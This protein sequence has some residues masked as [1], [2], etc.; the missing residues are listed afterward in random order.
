[1]S[2][3]Q[4]LTGLPSAAPGGFNPLLNPY[5][6]MQQGAGSPLAN[7]P[8]A[9]LA[10]LMSQFQAGQGQPPTPMPQMPQQPMQ[11]GPQQLPPQASPQPPQ[12]APQ[13]P[14][15]AAPA[16]TP[17]ATLQAAQQSPQAPQQPPPSPFALAAPNI[18]K[19]ESNNGTETGNGGGQYQIEPGMQSAFVA[20]N[21]GFAKVPATSPAYQQAAYNWGTQQNAKALSASGLNPTAPG[22]IYTAWALGAPA[23]TAL[24]QASDPTASAASIVSKL[25]GGAEIIKGNPDLF[26]SNATVDDVFNRATAVEQTGSPKGGQQSSSATPQIPPMVG[27]AGTGM[28]SA[29]DFANSV[30]PAPPTNMQAPQGNPWLSFASGMLSGHSFSDALGKGL[31]AV[32]QTQEQNQGQTNQTKVDQYNAALSRAQAS[33]NLAMANRPTPMGYQ[34]SLIGGDAKNPI[35]GMSMRDP[36]TGQV[37]MAP[38]PA[39][40]TPGSI[41]RAGMTQQGA[42]QRQ[43]SR[44]ANQDSVANARMAQMAAM[45]NAGGVTA[46]GGVTQVAP[47]VVQ[48]PGTPGPVPAPAPAPAGSPMSPVPSSVVQAAQAKLAAQNGQQ[49]NAQ[50]APAA[51]VDPVDAAASAAAAPFVQQLDQQASG[52]QVDKTI[53]RAAMTANQKSFQETQDD[54]KAAG[55]ANV[56]AQ[57]ALD[58]I[59]ANPGAF[60][61]SNSWN[62]FNSMV[63]SKLGYSPFSGVSNGQLQ[64]SQAFIKQANAGGIG[65]LLHDAMGISRPSQMEVQMVQH[66]VANGSMPLQAMTTLMQSGMNQNNSTI[67]EGN[68]AKKVWNNG[69]YATMPGFFDSTMQTVQNNLESGK[70]PG[71]YRP[72]APLGPTNAP[73]TG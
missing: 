65:D 22:M 48:Q 26:G 46:A 4:L 47:Q 42:S 66:A 32:D 52:Y 10:A 60:S 29:I 12:A 6:V 21:P 19:F 25:S 67:A 23:T 35:Y 27:P 36:M 16:A 64:L 37:Y 9:Q 44:L 15:Q 45:H 62:N 40:V 72:I 71:L 5:A 1:L 70:Y 58:A 2:G 63:S 38:L 53:G 51:P 68:I 20:A 41:V 59:N 3:S 73:A 39:G 33:I 54:A 24:A 30:L 69:K 13:Q 14:P 34:P 17:Q 49:P 31:G 18:S 61:Q 28:K 50:P 7:M 57:K 8:P 56:A 55:D 43:A 11:P